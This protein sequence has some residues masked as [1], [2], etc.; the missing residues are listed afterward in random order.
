VQASASGNG[1]QR[2]CS[3]ARVWAGV[4]PNA[5]VWG[6]RQSP[7]TQTRILS[8]TWKGGAKRSGQRERT[9]E[10]RGEVSGAGLGRREARRQ[11][12][13][14]ARVPNNRKDG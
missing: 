6:R 8:M 9:T 14:T 4:K 3:L 13:G 10:S 7:T 2:A 1:V 12:L 11:G 5:G